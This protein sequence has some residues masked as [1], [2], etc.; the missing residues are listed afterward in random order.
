MPE[1]NEK[2]DVQSNK[3]RLTVII[4]SMI[5]IIASVISVIILLSMNNKN[6]EN[7]KNYTAHEIT[8]EI[9]KGMSY[10]NLSEI[11]AENILK[12]YEIPDG[13]ISD[14]AMYISSKPDS[15]TEIACF[16]MRSEDSEDKLMS[17]I[18]DY[19][20]EK[21]SSYQNVNEK[22]YEAVRDS[23]ILKH[24]PYVVVSVST[25]NSSVETLFESI[26]T[27]DSDDIIPEYESSDL[28]ASEIKERGSVVE[29]SVDEYGESS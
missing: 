27:Q 9:I 6:S 7:E 13:T 4:V 1:K 10:E 17:S 15:F 26:F 16:R 20:N 21:I 19:I 5:I 11:S 29:L 14:S 3:L 28:N 18:N 22:A 12:Y 2:S 24:Y 25:D 8:D 23:R